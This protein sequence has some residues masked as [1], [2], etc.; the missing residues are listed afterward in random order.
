MCTLS[1]G[2]EKNID[3]G[4]ATWAPPS[5]LG[6]PYKPLHP[7]VTFQ[8]LKHLPPTHRVFFLPSPSFS[9][10]HSWFIRIHPCLFH[11]VLYTC[12]F[13][14][15][16][17]YPSSPNSQSFSIHSCPFH[18]R[19]SVSSPRIPYSLGFLSFLFR[20][21]FAFL[22]LHIHHHHRLQHNHK[23]HTDRWCPGGKSG[24]V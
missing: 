2:T 17:L 9:V 19:S 20:F 15:Y 12:T 1:A 18:S 8:S 5:F 23:N 22:L 21:Y 14:S 24:I 10:V 16:F 3:I 6:R 4:E 7:R 11:S 13:H